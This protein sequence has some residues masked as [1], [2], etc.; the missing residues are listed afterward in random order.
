MPIPLW[1]I[2]DNSVRT[3]V[4]T[5]TYIENGIR[6]FSVDATF[7]L[8][9]SDYIITAYGHIEPTGTRPNLTDELFSKILEFQSVV[10]VD[11]TKIFTPLYDGKNLYAFLEDIDCNDKEKTI[12]E[13]LKIVDRSKLSTSS[14][15]K[16]IF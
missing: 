1:F 16:K 11:R 2:K 5:D 14:L 3:T 13:L 6:L 8:R 10:T 9:F 12:K 4:E 7:Q 15:F